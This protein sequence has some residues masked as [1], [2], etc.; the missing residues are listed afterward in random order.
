MISWLL[1]IAI[2]FLN[3]L[4]ASGKYGI[5][6]ISIRMLQIKTHMIFVLFIYFNILLL[7]FGL[8]TVSALIVIN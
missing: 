3:V 1:F 2:E 5:V 7:Y 4:S 6:E 8:S